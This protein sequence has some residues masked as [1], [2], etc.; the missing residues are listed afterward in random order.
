MIKLTNIKFKYLLFFLVIIILYSISTRLKSAPELEY[1]DAIG[2]DFTLTNQHGKIK[3]LNNFKDKYSLIFFGFTNCDMICPTSLNNMSLLYN[4]LNQQQKNNLNIIFVTIDPQRDDP[5]RLKE[6][7]ANFSAPITGLTGS[8]EAINLIKDKY[9]IY[10][11]EANIG[12]NKLT[13]N[14]SSF[15]YLLNKEGKFIDHVGHDFKIDM[16]HN[17]LNNIL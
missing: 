13:I 15:I 1:N 14:H 5:A 6:Y 2:G 12:K 10:A 16:L 4:K 17:K 11:E 9:K 8:K 7:L 3:T